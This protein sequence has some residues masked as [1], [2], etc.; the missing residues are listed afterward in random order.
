MVTS[1]Q[2]GSRTDVVKEI[3]QFPYY[4][5]Y[6]LPASW[7]YCP[8]NS[9]AVGFNV[10]LERSC[11]TCDDTGLDGIKLY[12]DSGRALTSTQSRYG[13][14]GNRASCLGGQLVGFKLHA[15]EFVGR[16]VGAYDDLGG[17]DFEGICSPDNSILPSESIGQGA[18]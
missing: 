6:L 17:I 10:K 8:P 5:K 15:C 18:R 4:S 3:I 11:G 9:W 14:W 1:Y 12:C 2:H 7:E 13:E 16:G